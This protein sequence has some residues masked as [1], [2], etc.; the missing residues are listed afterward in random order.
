MKHECMPICFWCTK[1]T[2]KPVQ[3]SE[4]NGIKPPTKA[5]LNYEP[6]DACKEMFGKGIHIIGVVDEPLT[7]TMPPIVND[8]EVKL[9]PTGAFFVASPEWTEQMLK[10]NNNQQ[11][12]EHV[13]KQ[14]VL[15]MPD[16]IVQNIIREAEGV[17]AIEIPVM[18]DITN[19][20][21]SN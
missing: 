5:I 12:I 13:L 8:G 11:M 20:N 2:G 14:R 15:M 17:P 7:E 4:V 3:L 21:N 18:E 16:E 10:A 1:E 19:E 9:Y 6:C